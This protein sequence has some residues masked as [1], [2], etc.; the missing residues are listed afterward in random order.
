MLKRWD[1]G[2]LFF[3][4]LSFVKKFAKKGWIRS[5]RHRKPICAVLALSRC[6]LPISSPFVAYLTGLPIEKSYAELVYLASYGVIEPKGLRWKERNFKV[7]ET[8]IRY[9]YR[10][11]RELE[12]ANLPSK[13]NSG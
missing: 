12:N 9:M 6:G 5:K 11:L 2:S 8:F 10:P 1:S 13:G 3:H 4:F 7:S